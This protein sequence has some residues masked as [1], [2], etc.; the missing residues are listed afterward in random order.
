[1]FRTRSRSAPQQIIF[2]IQKCFS[3]QFVQGLTN[4]WYSHTYNFVTES[5]Y[6][7]K[8]RPISKTVTPPKYK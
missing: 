1:M 5:R 8:L 2:G 7:A 3:I 4:L 6:R